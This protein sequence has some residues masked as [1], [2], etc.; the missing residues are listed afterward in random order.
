MNKIAIVTGSAGLIGSQAVRLFA[1]KGF[2]T[3]GID[4]DL[5]SSFFG[6][7]ASTTWLRDQ[8][9]REVPGYTHESVDIREFDTLR[10]IF[11]AQGARIATV[12]HCAAQPSHNWASG[13]PLIDFGVNAL[14]TLNLLEL[15]RQHC[16]EA[17][18]IFCSTNNVYGEH[19]N[20]LPL[21][22]QET[23]WELPP[24]HPY[25]EH[26][27]DEQLSI[28]QTEHTIFGASKVAADVMVQEYGRHYDMYTAA[29]R[30]G[31]LTGPAHSAAQLHGFLAYLMK[32]TLTGEPY[33][34]LGYKGKQVR[35]NIHA[36]DLVE[37]FWHFYQNPRRGEVYNAGGGRTS[38]CSMQEAITLCSEI[39][40]RET[41]WR[42]SEEHRRGDHIWW[43]SDTRRF[44]NHYPGW[45]LTYN[46]RD[47]LTEIRDGLK[48]RLA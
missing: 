4:N 12:I 18:F 21:I 11:K 8:L 32:C 46:M 43:V 33:T 22:E 47:I 15:T 40:G 27:I 19:C 44:Q 2:D 35:D 16:P 26:G 34:V 36:S 14:G 38:H 5:R 48:E 42:Y 31:C 20:H 3:I 39:A 23:R 1:A 30:G 17:V 9:L 45:S 13:E 37:M 25:F 29:F 7:E 6:S 10:P 24:S 28:D 41:N